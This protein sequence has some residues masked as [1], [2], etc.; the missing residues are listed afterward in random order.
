M[1]AS[2][3]TLAAAELDEQLALLI[4][5]TSIQESSGRYYAQ[6]QLEALFARLEDQRIRRKRPKKM[7]ALLQTEV[8][9]TFLKQHQPQADFRTLIK[10]GQYNQST[11][12]AL[13][14]LVLSYFE[15]PY[16]LQVQ[17][18]DLILLPLPDGNRTA[19]DIPHTDPLSGA[20][21]E[22][23]RAA[24]V[25]LL[26][27]TNYPPASAREL[28]NE[29]LYKRYY[30]EEGRSLQLQEAAAFMYYQQALRAY[31][32][33]AWNRCQDMLTRA[34]QLATHP[35]LEILERAIWLQLASQGENSRESTFYLWKLWAVHPGQPWQDELLK[36]FDHH[37]RQLPEASKWQIDSI[38]TDFQRGFGEHADAQ[39]CLREHY[40]VLSA[41]HE[42]EA[43]HTVEVLNLMDSLYLL[44]PNQADIQQVLARMMVWSLRKE[45]RFTEGLQRI[46]Y[47]QKHYP[48]VST[49]RVF[50]DQ[51]LFYRAEQV[52]HHFVADDEIAG[53]QYLQEF[54]TLLQKTGKTPRYAAWVTTAYLAASNYYFR[55]EQYPQARAY[56]ERALAHAPDDD[57]LLHRRDLL[58]RY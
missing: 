49:N 47:Y 8:E 21:A 55:Q 48:F 51:H 45:R 10:Q 36:R 28:S 30:L 11:A 20:A 25:D 15:I 17:A 14:A 39:A 13:Y 16:Q 4:P 12:T 26:R 32:H 40:F 3:G 22:R 35:M 6:Q 19:L 5:G 18:A 2:L 44:R 57:Y 24:Y 37:V 50:Q 38:Y 54:E 31:Q 9:N 1:C 43:G 46:D 7:L 34:R 33:Q 52:H 56:I 27:A 42:A 29:E 41:Q 58:A 23:F 53:L